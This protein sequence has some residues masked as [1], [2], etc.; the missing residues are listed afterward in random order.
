MMQADDDTPCAGPEANLGYAVK[1]AHHLMRTAID[2]RIRAAGMAMTFP[3]MAA[4]FP[5]SETPGLSGAQLA[6]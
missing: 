4:L 1:Q 2:H 5:L 3:H 6:R